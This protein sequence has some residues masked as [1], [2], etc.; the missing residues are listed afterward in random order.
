MEREP[1]ATGDLRTSPSRRGLARGLPEVLAQVRLVGEAA[2]QR[3]V[4]QGRI[5]RKHVLSGQFH[6]TSHDERVRWL[7]EGALEGSREMRCAALNQRA[8]IR[9]EDRP[10]DINVNI[11]THLARLPG[12]QALS[13]VG[14]LSRGWWMNLASQ[15]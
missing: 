5:G 11:V 12:Q 1:L 4:T 15:Q 8:E 10:C 14:D 3:N 2:T 9:D 6:A 7:P 13:S